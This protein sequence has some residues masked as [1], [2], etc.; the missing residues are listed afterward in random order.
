MSNL[1]IED[2]QKYIAKIEDIVQRQAE[3]L[4]RLYEVEEKYNQLL[5][6]YFNLLQAPYE[7]EKL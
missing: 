3:E 5:D 2:Y 4:N 6:K 7:C 1:S